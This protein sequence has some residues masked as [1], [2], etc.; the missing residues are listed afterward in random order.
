MA[1]PGTKG[2]VRVPTE[3]TSAQLSDTM[4]RAIRGSTALEETV[5]RLLHA[6]KVGIV[7]PGE[8][9]PG[10][11]ELILR[12]RVGRAT[13]REA[14]AALREAGLIESRPGRGGG[15]FVRRDALDVSAK[16]FASRPVEGPDL[17]DV[18]TFRRAVEIEAARAA[19][20]RTLQEDD[21]SHLRAC[22]QRTAA[23]APEHY[24]QADSR[25]HLAI[26]ELSGSPLLLRA[27]SEAELLVHDLLAATPLIPTK[28]KHSNQQHQVIVDAIVKG[29]AEAA[30][31]HMTD[32]LEGTAAM[33]RGFFSPA[34][35]AASPRRARK[36]PGPGTTVP[37]RTRVS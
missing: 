30:Q 15:S 8:R 7:L 28:L 33:L 24:R 26:A 31:L 23:A 5:E 13:L 11:R 29:D 1:A 36:A 18:L 19:A 34:E 14:L 12:F 4:F 32:H 21:E 27:V 37:A 25:L 10:E 2:T 3:P 16:H 20:S 17:H 6:I 22:L 35:V 9:L